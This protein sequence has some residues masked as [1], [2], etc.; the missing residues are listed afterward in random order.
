MTRHGLWL[1]PMAAAAMAAAPLHAQAAAPAAAAP[2]PAAA[3]W[4]RNADGKAAA[5]RLAEFLRTAE[6]DGFAQGS[7]LAP[8][9]ESGIA[10]GLPEDE[11]AI[12][13]AWVR[14][15]QAMKRPV[16]GVDYGDP[17][18]ALKMPSRDAILS[19]AAAA[20][21]LAAHVEAVAGVN[22]F[23]AALRSAAIRQG[24]AGDPRVRATLDRLRLV[25]GSGRAVLV[26]VANAE[27]MLLEDGRVTDTMKVIVGKTSYA[28]PLLAGTM[29]YVTFNPYWHI[30]QD[31][32]RRVV[33]PLILKRGTSY[34]KAARYE[35]VSKFAPGAEL[36]DPDSIDWKA[37]AAGEIEANI[38]QKAGGNNM[39][40]MMKF[41]FVNDH[42]I[43]LHDT[44]HK[45]LFA[46]AKRT[47]SL[48]CVRVE[49]AERFAR[50]L[51]GREPVAPNSDTEQLVQIDKG[52]PIYISYLTARPDGDALAFAADVYGLDQPAKAAAAAASPTAR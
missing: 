41:G 36:V 10:R 40:G 5:T 1:V 2:A 9:V 32:A 21:S 20:P 15:V 28:T 8:A 52:V 30:P 27:M 4:L 46:K 45:H 48:G 43:F 14:Y 23:R 31:V 34:L 3:L 7:S 44:P 37:V 17:Q 12:S 42:G 26:D 22:A 29:H 49:N 33:A 38:R 11:L 50:W 35:T 25:P 16:T 19:Q 47:L 13:D 51:L 6:I 18:R 39:M 24:T